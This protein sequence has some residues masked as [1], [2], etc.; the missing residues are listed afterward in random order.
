MKQTYLTKHLKH[1]KA[2]NNL[3]TT[4]ITEEYAVK[5]LVLSDQESRSLYEYFSPEKIA[6]TDLIIAC[7][8]LKP[9]YLEFFATMGNVPLVYVLGNHDKWHLRKKALGCICIEDDIFV[10]NGIRILGLGGS[11]RY[12]P[13][14]VCQFNEAEM[15]KRVRK[16]WKKLLKHK[17]FDILVTHSPAYGF[18]DLEDLPHQGFQCFHTLIERYSPKFFIHGHV[19]ANYGGGSFKREDM[20]GQTKVI[21][22]FEHY[23]IEY[24]DADEQ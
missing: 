5:I 9:E 16:L 1:R 21:N 12:L 13:D 10:Y 18:N 3:H 15:Q 23:F 17:G 11:M 7:G 24:P 2:T 22:A 4:T 19:H 8:D 6:G 20:L 14:T